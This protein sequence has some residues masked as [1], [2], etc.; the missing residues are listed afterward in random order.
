MRFLCSLGIHSWDKWSSLTPN[1][2]WQSRECRHCRLAQAREVP[3]WPA[4]SPETANSRFYALAD[5]ADEIMR[6]SSEKMATLFQ[7]MDELFIDIEA[8]SK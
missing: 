2:L 8:D 5:R 7:E 3:V 6:D 4:F 1:D